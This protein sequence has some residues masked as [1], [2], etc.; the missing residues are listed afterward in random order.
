MHSLSKTERFLFSHLLESQSLPLSENTLLVQI[1]DVKEKHI[2]ELLARSEVFDDLLQL[3]FPNMKADVQYRRRPPLDLV[4]NITPYS[5]C[6]AEVASTSSPNPDIL[7]YSTA[8]VFSKIKAGSSNPTKR[9][10]RKLKTSGSC[11][12]FSSYTL[13][14]LKVSLLANPSHVEVVNPI[15]LGKTRAKQFALLTGKTSPR[16]A[17]SAIACC[18]LLYFTSG[19]DHRIYHF[20]NVRTLYCSDVDK[21]INTPILHANGNHP[22]G[23]A[24][25]MDITTAIELLQQPKPNAPVPAYRLLSQLPWPMTSEFRPPANVPIQTSSAQQTFELAAASDDPGLPAHD[26]HC[27]IG[28]SRRRLASRRQSLA[29]GTRR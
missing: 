24:K 7:R 22:E 11:S 8:V 15:V 16:T 29:C 10:T 26:P 17:D 27:S 19:G 18:D 20:R 2:H 12:R 6:P 4:P 1:D 13:H 9:L 3:E 25:A 28:D 5:F 14:A 21:M 23:V